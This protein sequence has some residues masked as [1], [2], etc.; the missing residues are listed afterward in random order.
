M[1]STIDIGVLGRIVFTLG[2]VK[3]SHTF[4]EL[5]IYENL[6]GVLEELWI[7]YTLFSPWRVL[8]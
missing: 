5:L 6:G 2:E 7:Y 8:L 3:A 4:K 1:G